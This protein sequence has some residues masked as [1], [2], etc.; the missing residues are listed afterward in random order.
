MHLL[1]IINYD[2]QFC[3]KNYSHHFRFYS[4]QFYSNSQ[5]NIKNVMMS[6]K[7]V[8]SRKR[9][10]TL[11]GT[12]ICTCTHVCIHIQC[13]MCTLNTSMYQDFH[14]TSTLPGFHT[15]G[16]EGTGI[17]PQEFYSQHEINKFKRQYA[18]C[19]KMNHFPI[20][21]LG[22][23]PLMEKSNAKLWS[24]PPKLKILYET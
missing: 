20:L 2:K 4:I 21:F 3:Y 15:G 10:V 5:T 17:S 24:F 22:Y 18:E 14:Q 7:H 11:V 8:T 16:G 1:H 19:L 12:C 13:T 9:S 6:T 23:A